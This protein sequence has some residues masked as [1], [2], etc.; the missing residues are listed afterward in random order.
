MNKELLFKTFRNTLGAA[1]YIF[2]VSQLMQNGGKLFGETENA[3]MPFVILLLFSLS[4]A[5]VGSL[6][7]GLS[8][9][10]F[11]S[12]KH[13]EGI[14]AGLYSIAW[15]GLYTIIGFGILLLLK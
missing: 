5:V 9:I 2:A 4:A 14:K 13:A 1:V 15:L 10:L 11:L 3:F 6:I 7:L 12:K 8:V